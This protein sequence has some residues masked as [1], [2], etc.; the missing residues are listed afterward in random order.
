MGVVDQPVED[1]IGKRRN[2]DLATLAG[3]G[4]KVVLKLFDSMRV[5]Q[6]SESFR[7]PFDQSALS[8]FGMAMAP[9]TLKPMTPAWRAAGHLAGVGSRSGLR[10]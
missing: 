10:V 6:P 1:A 2:S 9:A 3:T 8:P 7:G 4:G 5:E